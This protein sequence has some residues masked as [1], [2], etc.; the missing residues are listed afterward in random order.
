MQ[1][2]ASLNVR[3]LTSHTE[4]I[5]LLAVHMAEHDLHALALIE[6]RVTHAHPALTSASSLGYSIFTPRNPHPPFGGLS[7][8]HNQQ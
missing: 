1:N 8:M 4:K 7:V 3:G 5:E 2:V 6:A